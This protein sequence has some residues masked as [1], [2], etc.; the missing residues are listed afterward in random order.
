LVDGV[1][2]PDVDTYVPSGEGWQDT[3]FSVSGLANGAHSLTIEA[4]GAKNPAATNSYI[5]VDAFDVQR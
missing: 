2:Y 3:V 4:M 1:R 5:I